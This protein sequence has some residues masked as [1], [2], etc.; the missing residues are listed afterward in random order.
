MYTGEQGFSG[1]R[2]GRAGEWCSQ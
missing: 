2:W 1:G